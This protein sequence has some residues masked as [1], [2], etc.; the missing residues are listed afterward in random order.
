MAICHFI[1]WLLET[2]VDA[3]TAGGQKG[4]W[5]SV[6]FACLCLLAIIALFAAL[7]YMFALC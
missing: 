4:N 3:M 7:V 1:E 5:G 6:L 2:L